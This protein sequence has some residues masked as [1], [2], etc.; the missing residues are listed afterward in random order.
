MEP[1]V[2]ADR[3]ILDAKWMIEGTFWNVKA[4]KIITRWNPSSLVGYCCLIDSAPILELSP[5]R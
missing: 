2:E 3:V 5:E 1:K 4:G